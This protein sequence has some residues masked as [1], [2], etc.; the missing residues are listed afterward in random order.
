MRV[1]ASSVS[2][3]IKFVG[4]GYKVNLLFSKVLCFFSIR[5]KRIKKR[6]KVNRVTSREYHESIQRGQASQ[7]RNR[8]SCT[9]KR[10][11]GRNKLT[12]NIMV[13]V[14]PGHPAKGAFHPNN[15]F[16]LLYLHQHSKLLFPGILLISDFFV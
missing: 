11:T 13:D 12:E 8:S 7:L 2:C 16:V 6:P 1:I 5:Y 10:R 4:K 9:T 3:D 14:D 15:T